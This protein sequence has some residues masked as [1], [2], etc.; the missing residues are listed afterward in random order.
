MEHSPSIPADL[1]GVIAHDLGAPA[2]GKLGLAHRGQQPQLM[3][4]S[5]PAVMATASAI[6][7]EPSL[8]DSN[9]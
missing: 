8:R 6:A 4:P 9:G 7:V 5:L 2:G 1:P 3:P